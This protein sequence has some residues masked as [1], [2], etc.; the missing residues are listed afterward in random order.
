MRVDDIHSLFAQRVT[1]HPNRPFLRTL[2][3]TLSYETVAESVDRYARAFTN[4][5]LDSDDIL[6]LFLDNRPEFVYAL[7][8]AAKVGV[9]TAC[10]NTEMRGE[11]FTHL[12]EQAGVSTIISSDEHLGSHA[13]T[14]KKTCVRRS[15]SVTPD[16]DYQPIS[17]LT[18][19]EDGNVS[20]A[21]PD[22][23]E[24]AMLLHTSGTT[25][26]PKWCELSHSYFLRL[27]TYVSDAFEIAPTDVVFNPLPLYHIN[28]LG[29]SFF[30]GL[31]SGATIGLV[32]R[33]SVSR[34]WDQVDTLEASVVVLHM[35][36]KNM[37]LSRTTADE[38]EGH[39]I[40]VM[41]P[42]DRD[43]MRRFDIPKMVTGYGS[44]EAGGL[45]HTNTFTRVPE[46]LPN[47]ENLSQFAGSPRD[48]IDVRIVDEQGKTVKRG[49]QGEI[50][51]RPN[52]PGAIFDGYY[53]EPEK[54]ISTWEQ[55]WF[56]TGDLGYIDDDGLLHF[57]GR[58]KDSISHKGQF[59]N[60][61]LVESILEEHPAV[62]HSVV[63]GVADDVVG[64]RVKATIVRTTEV[65]P[66][67]LKDEVQP[68]LPSFMVP[69]YIEFVDAFPRI[70]GTEKI[71][72][73]A[74]VERGVDEAHHVK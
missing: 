52:S 8:G 25:G 68:K 46:S 28:P 39:S 20:P 74:I 5:G 13:E 50:Y 61:D 70:E 7:L 35:A 63:V 23:T 21:T 37:I 40:R 72:R 49:R 10:I 24:R 22:S 30:G 58:I 12:L 67:T 55:L 3:G 60:I 45:T 36:P 69:E 16:S 47:E 66:T 1:D 73:S 11:G 2:D 26:L 14:T 33:F 62:E 54:T 41:F 48:D 19:T 56:N 38:A 34:F 32:E 64:E 42:A 59:V 29:Y 9:T 57:V 18:E 44:T 17:E 51:I 43:F 65:A 27:G 15:L 31:T 4:E 71:N 53:R 6:A